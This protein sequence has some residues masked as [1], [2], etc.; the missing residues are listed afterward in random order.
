[1]PKKVVP[2]TSNQMNEDLPEPEYTGVAK[3]M[4]DLFTIAVVKKEPHIVFN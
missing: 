1:M 3:E 4:N 2:K